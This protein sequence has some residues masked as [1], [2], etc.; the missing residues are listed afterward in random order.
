MRKRLIIFTL[1]LVSALFFF[2]MVHAEEQKY[3]PLCSM[4]LKMFWK[5]THWLTFADGTRSGYCSIHCASIVYQKRAANIDRW[6]VADY[7]TKELINAH[8][9]HFLI[10]SDLP[11]TMTPV[12]KLA[13]ASLD[14]AKKYQKEH[15]G[16]IST[17][18]DALRRAIEGRGEDMAMIKK[19]VVKMSAMGKKLAGK[20][21]CY[22]CHGEGG[23]GGEAIG[24]NTKDFAK[25][26]DNRVK[27]KEK[28]LGGTPHKMEGY[29]GKIT[30]KQ[31]HAI[32]LY[33]WVNR[34][35]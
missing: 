23:T 19:K 3:C 2:T 7:D 17:F 31:L 30:E 25:S 34:A 22:K 29:K 20:Y 27:I 10:G 32:T 33:I 8:K 35:K 15:G 1:I 21:G 13:F 24:W 18:D 9:A 12:S 5:T 4:N 28:I 6:E 16:T 14:V 26:M 11:G